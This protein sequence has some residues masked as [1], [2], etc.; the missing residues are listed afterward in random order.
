MLPDAP[1]FAAFDRSAGRN[2]GASCRSATAARS[3]AELACAIRIG[4]KAGS[5]F[6]SCFPTWRAPAPH[7]TP[8]HPVP[9]RDIGNPR[10][11]FKALRQNPRFLLR[12][13]ATSPRRSRDQ[14]N[15]SISATLMTV[16]KTRICH[17]DI[18]AL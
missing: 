13:P 3:R 11:G 5:P 7:Q 9:Q 6:I 17:R 8:I 14:L 15:A 12:R 18:S 1:A 16:I 2:T 4:T 10:S